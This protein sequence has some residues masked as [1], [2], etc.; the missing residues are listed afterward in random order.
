LSYDHSEVTINSEINVHHMYVYSIYVNSL[1]I[2]NHFEDHLFSLLSFVS[3]EIILKYPSIPKSTYI[4]CMFLR[5]TSILSE[6]IITSKHHSFL[7]INLFSYECCPGSAFSG[8][9]FRFPTTKGSYVRP[10]FTH[11]TYDLTS[12]SDNYFF[13]FLIDLFK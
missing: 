11:G 1:R 7:T 5:F 4:T 12:I 8:Y 3:Y 9:A 2:D 10:G 6:L 13:K